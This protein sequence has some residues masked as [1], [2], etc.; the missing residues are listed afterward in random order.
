LGNWVHEKAGEAPPR[1]Y[2]GE[3]PLTLALSLGEERESCLDG[4]ITL[5]QLATDRRAELDRLMNIPLRDPLDET[6]EPEV[7]A[8]PGFQDD[9]VS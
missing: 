9:V 3:D 8:Q 5:Q 7:T 6:L 1:P 2:I 4:V